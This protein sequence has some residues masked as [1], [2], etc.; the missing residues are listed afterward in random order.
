MSVFINIAIIQFL[1]LML[2]GPDFALVVR[3]ALCLSRRTAFF[4]ALGLAFGMATTALLCAFLLPI[5]IAH[6]KLLINI[7]RFLGAIYLI[8]LSSR[9]LPYWYIS[10]YQKS[11]NKIKEKFSIHVSNKQGLIQGYLCNISNP[12]SWLFY[13]SLFS[14]V[15]AK[16]ISFFWRSLS[17]IE[18]FLAGWLWFTLVVYFLTGEKLKQRLNYFNELQTWTNRIASVLFLVFAVLLIFL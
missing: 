12:K 14:L 1:A 4:T 2:P 9:L 8:W 13:I 15:I 3:N 16:N 7:V 6:E 18:M 11:D 5:F 17:V 10:P